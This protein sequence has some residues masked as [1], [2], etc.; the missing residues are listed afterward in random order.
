VKE[1][2]GLCHKARR[3]SIFGYVGRKKKKRNKKN[4][5]VLENRFADALDLWSGKPLQGKDLQDWLALANGAREE[6]DQID[7]EKAA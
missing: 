6:L 5:P 2:A 1:D 4:V 3:P 7:K